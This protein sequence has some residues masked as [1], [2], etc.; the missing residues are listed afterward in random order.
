MRLITAERI[1][2]ARGMLGNALL[3]DGPNVLAT[4]RVS[5]LRAGSIPEEHHPGTIIVPGFRDAHL[6]PVGYASS[7]TGVL[8]DGAGTIEEVL[9][10][11][12]DADSRLS[13]G[14]AIIGSLL[15]DERLEE[16]RLPDRFD[17]DGS[18]PTRPVLLYRV[19]GHIAVANTRALD[20]AGI[21]PDS[22]DPPG[23]SFDRADGVPN[24]ILRE[25]AVASV[26]RALRPAPT[27]SA[28]VE[29]ALDE[30][31][32]LGITSIGGI[33]DSDAGLW[34]SS[35][36]VDVLSRSE[37]PLR[38]SAFVIANTPSALQEA[39]SQL[40]RPMIR[41]GGLKAFS[42]G[43]LGGHTAALRNPYRDVP[44]TAGT[45]RLDRPAVMITATQALRLGGSVAIHAIG[46]AAV[47]LVLDVFDS[48]IEA[49]T[50]PNRL[51]M[52]HAS[53]MTDEDLARMATQGSSACVQPPFVVS[54]GPWLADRLGP[55]GARLAYRFS[56]MLRAGIPLAGG[57]DAPVE[58][59]NPLLG[60]AAARDR[61]GFRPDQD[62]TAE[63][64]LSLYTDDAARMLGE[65]LPL[66]PGSP[67]DF[68]L[69]DVDPVTAT[70]EELRDAT[71]LS[72]WVNGE[73]VYG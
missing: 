73:K 67:A 49:E 24:G 20:E 25:T 62:L 64:A 65:S 16:H 66:A 58:S 36:E 14:T 56:D 61:G 59:P 22:P 1:R 35:S 60:I 52:E 45:I 7:R 17:L 50:A 23:G 10:A 40:D 3:V 68:L 38:V 63:Q 13:P 69:L 8:L 15:D 31:L 6:H 43:S 33:V 37:I 27:T 30:F 4:G 29:R 2:T 26:A 72:T 32:G 71:V 55:E 54:D 41:F 18:T 19:C 12:R 21:G 28:D 39:A 48:L 44:S 34:S 51:R 53:I 42:D 9:S 11:V 5:D 46:D 57:S 70:P 47:D